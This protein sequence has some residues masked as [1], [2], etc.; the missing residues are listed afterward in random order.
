MRGTCTCQRTPRSSSSKVLVG[1][2]GAQSSRDRSAATSSSEISVAAHAPEL[3]TTC[4]RRLAESSTPMQVTEGNT[5]LV[6][7]TEDADTIKGQS[8]ER[9]RAR[10]HGRQRAQAPA[11]SRRRRQQKVFTQDLH[12]RQNPMS[13]QTQAHSPSTHPT[14]A[15]TRLRASEATTRSRR[16]AVRGFVL[17]PQTF[18]WASPHPPPAPRRRTVLRNYASHHSPQTTNMAR[19]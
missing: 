6:Q 5:L 10:T 15:K 4:I 7:G 12:L 11:P 2:P 13:K 17:T 9:S 18:T 3:H 19:R 14:K 1:R 16:L 8:G